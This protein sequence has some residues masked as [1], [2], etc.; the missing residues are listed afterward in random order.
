MTNVR[1]VLA[2]LFSALLLCLLVPPRASAQQEAGDTELQ[3]SGSTATTTESSSTFVNTNVKIG[4]YFTRSLQFGITTSLS[5][6]IPENGSTSY[7]GRGGFFLNYSFLSGDATTVPYLGG[8]YSKDFQ[9]DFERNYGSAGLNGG[10]KFY[11]NRRT[12]FDVGGNY[13]FNINHPDSG[14]ILFQF[15]LSFIL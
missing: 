7:N 12:A 3:F 2:P 1:T 4:Q 13:L 6:T 14:I 11:I 9:T 15:G 10:L 5:A 8:Q